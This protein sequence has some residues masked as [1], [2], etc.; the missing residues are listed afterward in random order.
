MLHKAA[1]IASHLEFRLFFETGVRRRGLPKV[2]ALD[3]VGVRLCCEL[4]H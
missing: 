4:W 3:V 2:A 1:S